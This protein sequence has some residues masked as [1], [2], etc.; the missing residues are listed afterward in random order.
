MFSRSNA[1][2]SPSPLEACLGIHVLDS[3]LAAWLEAR[4]TAASY[5]DGLRLGGLSGVGMRGI[6]SK[7]VCYTCSYTKFA[8][9]GTCT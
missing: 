2:F 8:A 3:A 1:H 9:V 7:P 4:Q 6:K 5:A